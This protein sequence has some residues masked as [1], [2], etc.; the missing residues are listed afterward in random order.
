MRRCLCILV[1]IAAVAMNGVTPSLAATDDEIRKIL[2]ERIDRYKQSVGI[3]VGIIEPSDRRIISYGAVRQGDSQT[4]DGDTVFEIGSVTKVFTSLLL[5][6]MMQ[7]G[8]VALDDP[9]TKYL[10]PGLNT[11]T[12]NGR[13]ITLHDVATHTSGLP[14]SPVNYRPQNPADAYAAYTVLLHPM[15]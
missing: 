13:S 15:L 3:V 1:M 11:P 7:R 14:A 6:D 12:R 9:I 8:E 10:P 5:A 4:I 2:A